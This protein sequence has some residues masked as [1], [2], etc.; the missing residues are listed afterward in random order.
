MFCIEGDEVS[1]GAF[2]V[3]DD[4]GLWNIFLISILGFTGGASDRSDDAA[5][6]SS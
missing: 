2:E 5:V 1:G 6:C 4:E 3:G